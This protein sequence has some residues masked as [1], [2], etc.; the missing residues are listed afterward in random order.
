MNEWLYF[1]V[2]LSLLLVLQNEGDK[3]KGVLSKAAAADALR[4]SLELFGTVILPL[5]LYGLTRFFWVSLPGGKNPAVL[6]LFPCLFLV[7]RLQKKSD[8]FFAASYALCVSV[9]VRPGGSSFWSGAVP[10]FQ[11][12]TAMALFQFLFLGVKQRMGFSPMPK[13][14]QGFPSSLIAA[15]LL[16]LVLSAFRS[17]AL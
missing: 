3:P 15:S 10:T 17:A 1:A 6:V 14:L 2:C 16:A 13:S 8:L 5:S 11:V 7:S 9:A 4:R 12:C